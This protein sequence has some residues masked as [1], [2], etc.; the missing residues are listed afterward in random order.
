MK[1]RDSISLAMAME[2]ILNN[3]SFERM[4]IRKHALQFSDLAISEKLNDL[5][6]ELLG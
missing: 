4:L 5:Y 2:K 6:R 3:V 1:D